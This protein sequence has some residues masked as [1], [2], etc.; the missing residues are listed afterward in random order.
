MDDISVSK[1]NHGNVVVLNI[2]APP[3]SKTSLPSSPPTS[4]PLLS[5]HF[6]QKVSYSFT[7]HWWKTSSSSPYTFLK[8]SCSSQSAAYS[9]TRG[10]LLL[11]ICGL[12]RYCRERS[13]QQCSDSCGHCSGLGTSG[14]GSCLLS[15]PHLC[16]LQPRCHYRLSILQEIP[17]VSTPSLLNCSSHWINIGFCDSASSVWPKQWRVQQETRCLPRI[18]SFWDW[19]SSI[20]DGVHHHRLPYDSYLC[21]HNLQENS[22]WST[23]KNTTHIS[24][25]GSQSYNNMNPADQ[26]TR[27]VNHWCNGHTECYLCRVIFTFPSQSM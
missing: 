24:W 15:R 13:T 10:N 7:I 12:C 19:P 8:F 23:N 22:K 11:D 18:I 5:V 21:H 1:S 3:V 20:R 17:S 16:T 25:S 14:N 2:Q 27:G 9:G 6:M 4:P 26:G